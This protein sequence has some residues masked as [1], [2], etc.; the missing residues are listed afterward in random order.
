MNKKPNFLV[1]SET[2]NNENIAQLC[3]LDGYTGHHVF[4]KN[5]VTRGGVGGGVSIFTDRKFT[6]AKIDELCICDQTI[7]L[8]SLRIDMPDNKYIVILGIYK[9]H[10]DTLHNFTEKLKAFAQKS[11]ICFAKDVFFNK[12]R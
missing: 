4:R 11:L 10:S 1:I 12:Y 5:T 2:W 6:A 9:P 8:C 3:Q 7:E